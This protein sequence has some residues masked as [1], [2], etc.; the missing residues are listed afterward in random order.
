MLKIEKE[1]VDNYGETSDDY[2]IRLNKLLTDINYKREK[3]KVFNEVS[4]ILSIKKKDVRFTLF[5]V[6][7][8]TPRPRSGRNGI[9]Y[10]KGA[11]E[12]RNILEK[13]YNNEL[14]DIKMITTPCKF[15]CTAY[16][17]IPKT[18]NK[19][20]KV[21]AEMGLIPVISKTDWDNLAKTYCDMIQGT[22]LYDDALIHEGTMIKK[23]SLKPRIEI[24]IEY[25]TEYESD[26]NRKK[27]VKKGLIE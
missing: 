25:N 26:Y 23:Y 18:M 17:P 2:Y 14:H 6:P 4:R 21:L 20:E 8:A 11:A 13:L 27:M 7:K 10:V 1:Y 9:F 15:K 19:M 16:L 3:R 12:N 5:L 22:L 24:E